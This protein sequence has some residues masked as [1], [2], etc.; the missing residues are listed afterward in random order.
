MIHAK[1]TENHKFLP[2]IMVWGGSR[3]KDMGRVTNAP[4]T[5]KPT[6]KRATKA[7]L[8]S[9]NDIGPTTKASAHS[10]PLP[11][12][13]G[14]AEKAAL[15][16]LDNLCATASMANASAHL[17]HA[18]VIDSPIGMLLAIADAPRAVDNPRL[19]QAQAGPALRMLCFVDDPD[20]EAHIEK[21]CARVDAQLLL[22]LRD[23]QEP[24]AT[25]DV[26]EDHLGLY[27]SGK[28]SA[29]STHITGIAPLTKV[30][31]LVIAPFG[32]DFQRTV[33]AQLL[34]IPVGT[35][36]SYAQQACAVG[37][38]KAMRAVA[39][40]NGQNPLVLLVPCHR[41]IGKNCSLTGYGGG[42]GRKAWLIEHERTHFATAK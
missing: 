20:F 1:H 25:L 35:T 26:L 15:R 34:T 28:R 21:L 30:G 14:D 37:N 17:L 12:R 6:E 41:V 24:N 16:A 40:S 2:T 36:C 42:I 39:R 7:T 10:A 11:I 18:R 31:P 23:A 3:S 5:P 22:N 19:K 27:F 4:K 38:P 29:L 13:N 33:W 9:S 8:I 32:T